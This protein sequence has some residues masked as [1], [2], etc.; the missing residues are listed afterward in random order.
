VEKW[1]RTAYLVLIKEAMDWHK[2]EE[3][4]RTGFVSSIKEAMG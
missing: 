2:V 3:R 4:G 1:G